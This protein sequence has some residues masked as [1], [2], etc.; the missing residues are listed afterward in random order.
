MK[1]LE[2]SPESWQGHTDVPGDNQSREPSPHKMNL[3]PYLLSASASNKSSTMQPSP[4][5]I[6]T[7]QGSCP[8]TQ[9]P[10]GAV[11]LNPGSISESPRELF[12]KM[13]DVWV[14]FLQFSVQSRYCSAIWE[15]LSAYYVPKSNLDLRDVMLNLYFGRQDRK[16]HDYIIGNVSSNKC[17]GKKQTRDG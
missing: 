4:Y 16:T 2:V 7:A 8:G 13:S 10:F 3:E 11:V 17:Y 9:T 12:K 6:D 15:A 5:T 1:I 14:P